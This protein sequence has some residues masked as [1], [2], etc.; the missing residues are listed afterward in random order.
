M[1]LAYDTTGH[2]LR[3]TAADGEL[4]IQRDGRGRPTTLSHTTFGG[5]TIAYAADG[6][7]TVTPNVESREM[8]EMKACFRFASR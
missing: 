6:T 7:P 3:A 1:A 4:T 8:T 5:A 2:L